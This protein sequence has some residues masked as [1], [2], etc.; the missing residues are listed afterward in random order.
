MTDDAL[1]IVL[2]YSPSKVP[3]DGVSLLPNSVRRQ[4]Y[5][6]SGFLRGRILQAERQ[7]LQD[8]W[9]LCMEAVQNGA[10]VGLA[11]H[12]GR[13]S[14]TVVSVT[15][16]HRK[17]D[18]DGLLSSLKHG[19]DGVAR[20]LDVDDGRFDHQPVVFERGEPETRI[21]VERVSPP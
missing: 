3:P 16:A 19:F 11:A 9:A 15:M 17:P 1:T 4:R 18:G 14:V 20:A 12:S 2:P 13:F 5:M 21:T 10:G 8:A 6:G 7:M